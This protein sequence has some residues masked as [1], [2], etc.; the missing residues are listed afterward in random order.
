MQKWQAVIE[1]FV[2]SFNF[3]P[4]KINKVADALSRQFCNNE[5]P[6]NETV[7]SEKS[8]SNVNKTVNFPINQFRN[9]LISKSNQTSF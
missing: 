8:L 6:S 3:K 9:Q 5:A 1:E 4:G 7:Y 2:S